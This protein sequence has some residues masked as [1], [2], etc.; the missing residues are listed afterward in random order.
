MKFPFF[1]R[2]FMVLISL[3]KAFNAIENIVIKFMAIAAKFEFVFASLIFCYVRQEMLQKIEHQ[4][5]NDQGRHTH[6]YEMIS[7]HGKIMF[8]FDLIR[9]SA[10]FVCKMFGMRISSF[11]YLTFVFLNSAG[12]CK[13]TNDTGGHVESLR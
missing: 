12:T 8:S 9:L 10:P 7:N 4:V 1:Y 11:V 13:Q 6:G 5:G 3:C 2:Y